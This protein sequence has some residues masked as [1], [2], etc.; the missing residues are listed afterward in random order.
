MSKIDNQENENNIIFEHIFNS[1]ISIIE[2]PQNYKYGNNENEIT[3]IVLSNISMDK[4]EKSG[5]FSSLDSINLIYRT[6]QIVNIL[7]NIIVSDYIKFNQE[8]FERYFSYLFEKLAKKSKTRQEEI[9]DSKISMFAL[10]VVQQLI[11]FSIYGNNFVVLDIILKQLNYEINWRRINYNTMTLIISLNTFIEYVICAKSEVPNEIKA[12]LQQWTIRQDL[13]MGYDKIENL[14]KITSQCKNFFF[15]VNPFL[16]LQSILKYF[17]LWYWEYSYNFSSSAYILDSNYLIN[18]FFI[19][20]SKVPFFELDYSFFTVLDDATKNAIFVYTEKIFDED[21]KLNKKFI[22]TTKRKYGTNKESLESS[23]IFE[24]LKKY[25]QNVDEHKKQEQINLANSITNKE[26]SK[27]IEDHIIKK[28]QTRIGFDK[29][30]DIQGAEAHE[31]SYVIMKDTETENYQEACADV[32]LMPICNSLK[33]L[34]N[35][36]FDKIKIADLVVNDLGTKLNT[37]TYGAQILINKFLKYS[38][39]EKLNLFNKVNIEYDTFSLP[40][41]ALFDKETYKFNFELNFKYEDYEESKREIYNYSAVSYMDEPPIECLYVLKITYKVTIQCD[42]NKC[43][44]L[45]AADSASKGTDSIDKSNVSSVV[46]DITNDTA[47]AESNE[48]P[49]ESNK[50]VNDKKIFDTCDV[51]NE[52]SKNDPSTEKPNDET[53]NNE[54]S[55]TAGE[56]STNESQQNDKNGNNT[57]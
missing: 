8:A 25:K 28:L 51:E 1:I 45:T 11:T 13:I 54:Q 2:N 42:E 35:N 4:L 52:N 19:F 5:F 20:L 9:E 24:I 22:S 10:T 41:C 49:I 37:I 12:K 6:K 46:D 47:K 32:I 50:N 17:K 16:I 34:A 56:N 38:Y 29:E 53:Q 3:N 15:G 44:I 40:Y 43:F 21:Y 36:K 23:G 7:Y 39:E 14:K 30:L 27:T 31:L 33:R 18:S 55:Q 57:N 48:T 26:Y